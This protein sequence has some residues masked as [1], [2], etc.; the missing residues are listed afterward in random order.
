MLQPHDLITAVIILTG[1]FGIG[2]LSLVAAVCV[3]QYR[4]SE[5]GMNDVALAVDYVGRLLAALDAKDRERIR[6]SVR[7]V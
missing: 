2:V 7:D 4:V 1:L 3:A 6:G 5:Y